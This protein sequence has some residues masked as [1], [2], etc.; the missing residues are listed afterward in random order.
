M[1]YNGKYKKI[2]IVGL[3]WIRLCYLTRGTTTMSNPFFISTYRKG[4]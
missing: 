3:L 2:I 1:R 4:T